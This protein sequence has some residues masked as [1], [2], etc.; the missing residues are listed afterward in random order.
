MYVKKPK[1]Q[2]D[3]KE[4][5]DGLQLIVNGVPIQVEL[6][7]S[8]KVSMRFRLCDL[9]IEHILGMLLVMTHCAPE[10]YEYFVLH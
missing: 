5:Q 3:H 2:Y 10:L 6:G 1:I 4:I 9:T 8:V 7:L